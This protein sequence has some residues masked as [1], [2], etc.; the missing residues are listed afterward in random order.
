MDNAA[1]RRKTCYDDS[2]KNDP[3]VS[4]RI[5]KSVRTKARKL[6]DQLTKE[7]RTHVKLCEAFDYKF[8]N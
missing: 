2:M 6:A 7:R 4:V 8:S 5:R 3:F 1:L